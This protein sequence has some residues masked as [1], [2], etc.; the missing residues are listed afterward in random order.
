[1][2]PPFEHFWAMS[3]Q[4]QFYIVWFL[5]FTVIFF[6][7]RKNNINGI[8]IVNIFLI[9]LFALSFSYSVYLT[10][11]NQ[12]WAYFDVGT[13]VWEFS[14]G[15]LLAVNLTRIKIKS[16]FGDIIGWAGLIGLLLTGVVFDVSTMFPGYVALWPMFCAS[17]ILL[18][19][20]IN[21]KYGVKSFLGSKWMMKEIGRASCR[22]RVEREIGSE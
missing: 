13:R 3:I 20:N 1:M 8:K 14:L 5:L 18:S 16:L 4:G 6:I 15:G 17:V 12:P 21:S 2:S 10:E 19:G 22:E 11:V 9:S 7:L